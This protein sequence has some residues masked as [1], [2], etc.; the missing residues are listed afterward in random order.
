MRS[1]RGDSVADLP[2]AALIFDVDG[3]LAET[4][5][6]HREAFNR[7][8]AGEGLPYRWDQELYRS[9]LLVTG[10]QR[11]ITHFFAQSTDLTEAQIAE[12]TPR[13]HHAKNR[14]YG[15]AMAD[16][17]IELRPGV[18]DLLR[19]AR[20]AGRNL[21]IA[22]T[23]SRVNLEGLAR[24]FPGDLDLDRFG[25]I[26]CGEDVAALKPDPEVYRA[27]LERLGLPAGHCIAFEDTQNGVASAIGAGLRVVAIPS[28]Y[29]TGQD[30]S[31]ATVVLED[32]TGLRLAD[33]AGL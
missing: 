27:A 3:T 33:A 22:T 18:A 32:L 11:R 10:G 21:A 25:A 1:R 19:E 30:F 14:H 12:L 6:L 4:E 20:A 16:S 15:E 8:F 7:A 29:S 17:P 26:V 28:L 23:T 5:E 13:L 24:R 31:A 2:V 9:L